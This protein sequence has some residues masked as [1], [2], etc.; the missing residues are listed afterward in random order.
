MRF[1]RSIRGQLLIII[2]I[3]YL[4]PVVVL[5]SYIGAVLSQDMVEKT[6]TALTSGVEYAWTLASQR[7]QQVVTLARAATY[8]GELTEDHGLLAAGSISDA[9]FLRRARSYIERK[10]SRDE[11]LSFAVFFTDENPDLLISTSSG[12]NAIQAYQEGLHQQ[13]R[14]LGAS[15]DT[16]VVFLEDSGICC[17]I[18]NLL[19]LRME[20][21]GMLVLGLNPER[22]FASLIEL[23]GTWEASVA[24]RLGELTLRYPE[25]GAMP[26]G[27]DW[28]MEPS[29][30]HEREGKMIYVRRSTDTRDMTCELVV[31]VNRSRVYGEVEALRMLMYL[32]LLLLAPVLA[33]IAAYLHNRVIRPITQLS[34]AAQRIETGEL[35]VTVPVHTRDELGQLGTSFSNMSLRIRELIDKTYKEELALRDAQLQAMQSRINPHFINNALET[36]NWEAR[37]EGSERISSMVEAMR[38]LMD[39]SMSRQNRHIVPLREEIDVAKAYLY[40]INLRY[41]QRLTVRCETEE[42]AMTAD[43][44]LLTI[45]P[46]LENAVEHGIAPVGGGVIELNCAIEQDNLC[47]TVRN[48]GKPLSEQDRALIANAFSEAGSPNGHLGLNNIATR[49]RL[50]YD[51]RASISIDSDDEQYTVVR[52]VIP[53]GKN[54]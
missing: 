51:G 3:C 16:R 23:S 50:L 44:P 45:Q 7:L 53:Q 43:V 40:F 8:D 11:L 25:T 12:Q 35:G 36:I 33:V 48:N 24:V 37:L 31:T 38:V 42:T 20:R 34:N 15:L 26:A 18:R 1:I 29:G 14:E 4:T 49:L 54:R 19:D 52:I 22:V 5:S 13:V 9:E 41:G 47:I 27:F 2:L 32:L 10:Y 46:L 21:Y 6:K 28:Q 30:L 17:V 39:A